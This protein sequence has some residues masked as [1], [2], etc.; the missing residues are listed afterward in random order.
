MHHVVCTTSMIL[1]TGKPCLHVS[2]WK[3]VAS[4]LKWCH[5]LTIEQI[6]HQAWLLQHIHTHIPD[7]LR[8][9]CTTHILMLMTS[10]PSSTQ[11]PRWCTKHAPHI[12]CVHSWSTPI[13]TLQWLIFTAQS[14]MCWMIP[15]AIHIHGC[16]SIVTSVKSHEVLVCYPTEKQLM[17][18][19]HQNGVC[20]CGAGTCMHSSAYSSLVNPRSRLAM[21]DIQ[22]HSPMVSWRT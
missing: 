18:V 9:W 14:A 5:C 11:S 16:T 22:C 21:C 4:N 7:V 19:A 15:H 20:M 17:W 13:V 12:V 10:K 2:T 3:N 6:G 8:S 1:N